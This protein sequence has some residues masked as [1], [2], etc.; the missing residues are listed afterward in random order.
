MS[1][2][3]LSKYCL[4]GN[5]FGL[6][7]PPL[8]EEEGWC[9]VNIK[10]D[11][12][13][14]AE[15]KIT[16]F[17][18]RIS[19]RR[20]GRRGVFI[21][22]NWGS[23]KTHLLRELLGRAKKQGISNKEISGTLRN[24]KIAENN[25]ISNLMKNIF[26]SDD[27]NEIIERLS[28]EKIII[29]IDEAQFFHEL[30]SNT[31]N[32]IDLMEDIRFI[33]EQLSQRRSMSGIVIC[34]IP[35]PIEILKNHRPDIL[36]RF[37]IIKLKEDLSEEE[38]S[39]L[40]A[41]YLKTARKENKCEN[42]NI[43][44]L[45][46]HLRRLWPFT[47]GSVREILDYWNVVGKNVGIKH[48]RGFLDLCK[49]VLD[50]AVKYEVD[51]IQPKDVDECLIKY[52]EKWEKCLNIW[53]NSGLKKHR[54]LVYALYKAIDMAKES[55]PELGIESVFPETRLVLSNN[56]IIIPDLIIKK[57]DKYIII[58]IETKDIIESSRYEKLYKAMEEEQISGVLV[59]CTNPKVCIS[60]R[61]IGFK[62]FK[63]KN[64]KGYFNEI[65][66]PT[67]E[68]DLKSILTAGR[69][70]AFSSI[71]LNFPEDNEFR[72]EIKEILAGNEAADALRLLKIHEKIKTLE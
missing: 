16:D 34:M 40:I 17:I 29:G 49:K 5:P 71:D 25:K 18:E 3:K 2:S 43:N 64:K 30:S 62:I 38:A 36:D 41:E 7:Q 56:D 23:G 55:D 72:A 8:Y 57:S 33:V 10:L 9:F 69:L 31:K 39:E 44:N 70:I 63:N 6:G 28:N 13:S 53:R 20:P 37:D 4:K 22:G 24:I 59:I 48:L 14:Y 46:E 58:E 60:A 27:I 19:S 54:I 11:D 50:H 45:T 66:L 65:L 21:I 1:L 67:R 47:V 15:E 52:R 68:N 32:Y 51:E 12:G 26:E 35:G 42:E 61:R